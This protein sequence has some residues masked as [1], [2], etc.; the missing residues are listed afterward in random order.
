MDRVHLLPGLI[1]LPE[2]SADHAF[3]APNGETG[4]SRRRRLSISARQ[5][6]SAASPGHSRMGVSAAAGKADARYHTANFLMLIELRASA[7]LELLCAVRLSEQLH[8]ARHLLDWPNHSSV[9]K[10]VIENAPTMRPSSLSIW[11]M[12]KLCSDVGRPNGSDMQKSSI[13]R[14]LSHPPYAPSVEKSSDDIGHN[15]P[16]RPEDNTTPP[17]RAKQN[18]K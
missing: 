6:C 4:H 10:G 5:R 15:C 7:H 12:A 14:A 2:A 1:H 16:I 13:S 9:V 8:I 17:L 11:S 18:R 3:H